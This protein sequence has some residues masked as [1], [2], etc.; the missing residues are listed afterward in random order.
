MIRKLFALA[1]AAL[2]LPGLL[3][4][5]AAEEQ[6]EQI[7]A[8]PTD[9]VCDH[10]NTKTI[11]YF[12][13]SPLYTSVSS[14]SHRVSG[15]ATV[16]TVCVDCGEVLSSET[17][18]AEEI[19]PHSM[20]KGVCA[21]CGYREKT[22]AKTSGREKDLPGER[23]IYAQ[24]DNSAE[25]LMTLTLSTIDLDALARANVATVL[26]RGERGTAAIALEV[27]EMRALAKTNGA[28]LYLELEEQEDGSFFAGVCLVSG[29]SEKTDA[30]EEG[31]SLR[32]YQEIK[33]EV[34]ASVA[35][36][37]EDRLVET[38]STWNDRGFW[39]VPYVRE[40][41]YFLFQK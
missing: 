10:L 5:A 9:L 29:N 32:F 24:K 26:V 17:A 23:T 33:E 20:K 40:G 37:N 39:T 13:D 1:V 18:N 34:R 35:P 25:G 16:E 27:Q 6:P 28:D 31:V 3:C 8:T 36:V 11:I 2:L 19:R 15:S 22:K 14:A 30:G 12:Y 21:L 7:P 41:T 38:S 4:G